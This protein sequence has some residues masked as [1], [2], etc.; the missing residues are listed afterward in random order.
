MESAFGATGRYLD[1][2]GHTKRENT[3]VEVKDYS[4]ETI[5][6]E[7]QEKDFHMQLCD[8]IIWAIENPGSVQQYVF[9]KGV[10]E[11]AHD[12][13]S[14]DV[15]FYKKDFQT[16][17]S[18][19]EE[20]AEHAHHHGQDTAVVGIWLDPIVLDDNPIVLDGELD[21]DPVDPIVLDDN[22]IVLDDN[23]IVLD[24]DEYE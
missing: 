7:E 18:N 1:I 10:P 8:N 12:I 11:W 5:P 19:L 21:G 9:S 22:P 13:M 3:H 23:P 24:G 16:L 4:L 15:D 20:V 6:S 2:T 14:S 17:Q